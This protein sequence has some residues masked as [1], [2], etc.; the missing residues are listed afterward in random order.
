V[1][2]YFGEVWSGLEGIPGI[3]SV[4]MVSDMPFTTENRWAE[5]EFDDRP[6]NPLDPPRADYHAAEPGYFAVMGI[7]LLQGRLP[8]DTWEAETP[9]PVVV[10]AD[11]AA[12]HW[13][14]RD[15]LGS[16]FR[17][18]H[19]TLSLQVVGVVGDVRDDGYDAATEPIFYIPFGTMVQRR[20]SIVLNV[21]GSVSDVAVSVREA[22]ARVDPDVPAGDLR[23]LDDLLASTVARPRAA[24]LIGSVFAVLALLVAAAGIYGLLSYSVESRTREIGIR[25]AL[26]ANRAQLTHM[27]LAQSTQLMVW[28]LAL[29]WIAALLAGKALS[30]VIF[31]V[32][33]WDPASLILATLLLWVAG[34]AA[35]WLPAR[36]ALSI[37]PRDALRSE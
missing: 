18:S 22:V 4:G 26:G 17:R 20:M 8:G 7:P 31:G 16:T 23:M 15:P 29:G 13:P 24:S 32:R 11:M 12:R 21:T 9:T 5:L 30:G 33:V 25:S 6:S 27:V 10:N 2:R 36:R 19:D 14:G 34:T 37:D 3:G 1:K 28:G 35:A